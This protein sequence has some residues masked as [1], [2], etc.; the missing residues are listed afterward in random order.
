MELTEE[1]LK[2]I[3]D[4]VVEGLAKSEA[5]G[6]AI[7]DGVRRIVPGIVD[8]SL[9][10]VTDKLGELEKKLDEADDDDD[11][12]DGEPEK[13]GGKKPPA[14]KGEPTA[15]ELRLQRELE[16]VKGD[17]EKSERERKE[18][19]ERAA[20][21]A[22]RTDFIEAATKAGVDPDA[23][24]FVYARFEGRLKRLEESEGGGLVIKVSRESAG[25]RFDEEMPVSDWLSKEFL[26]SGEGSRFR[27]GKPAG[28][29]GGGRGGDGLPSGGAPSAMDLIDQALQIPSQ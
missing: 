17:F 14:K 7:G 9:K 26:P 11:D 28:G 24:D 27:K 1:Q 19:A 21:T 22:R 10:G 6:K 16:K 15:N 20:A 2:K 8:S 18:A 4:Q 29:S 23:V 25:R 13:G 12:D 3:T 5:F